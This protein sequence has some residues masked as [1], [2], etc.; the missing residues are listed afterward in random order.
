VTRQRVGR[1]EI[2]GELGRGATAVVYLARHP[3]LQRDV[4][5]K[6]LKRELA[7]DATVAERFLLEARLAS[8]LSHPNVITVYDFDEYRGRPFIAMEHLPRGSLRPFVGRLDLAEIFT[9]LEGLLAGLVH[10]EEKGVTHR[11]LKPENLMVTEASSIKIT[12][13][14]IAKAY[15]GAGRLTE[16]GTVVGSPAYIAPE[17][18]LG[19]GAGPLSDLYSVGI[20]AYE[21]LAGEPPFLDS[22]P[23]AIVI[24]HIHDPVPPLRAKRPD[25]DAELADWVERLLAKDPA[26]RPQGAAA[27]WK[28][29]EP[30][31]GSTSGPRP[32]AP[33]PED[34]A[35]RRHLPLRALA[36]P[37]NVAVPLVVLAVGLA[38]GVLWLVPVAAVV[39]A[40][41]VAVS[42]REAATTAEGASDAD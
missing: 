30:I 28:E 34:T 27:A 18:A 32:R 31:A 39:Y 19:H 23:V 26:D 8:S 38:I 11:D 16:P 42:L 29:L 21:L 36:H 37:F 14:G 9:V 7:E 40:A 25:L 35:D 20:V 24:R 3:D 33:G 4:A 13:F 15:R 17:R 1:Y 10:A 5:V 12:D 2:V 6:E 22:E 41:L